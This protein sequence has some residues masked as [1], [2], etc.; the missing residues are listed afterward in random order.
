MKDCWNSGFFQDPR[1]PKQF[2]TEVCYMLRTSILEA[3]LKIYIV[4]ELFWT[5]MQVVS[6]VL[7]MFSNSWP[8]LPHSH[9]G[10]NLKRAASLWLYCSWLKKSFIIGCNISLKI[11]QLIIQSE[12]WSLL[13]CVCLQQTHN[14]SSLTFRYQ[15]SEKEVVH[16]TG[17]F[18][19]LKNGPWSFST[20]KEPFN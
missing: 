16:N 10:L 15:I 7:V 19:P 9:C 3:S 5:R 14:S 18:S 12:K 2:N 4:S 20:N 6:T 13:T 1:T 11:I 8:V 17:I